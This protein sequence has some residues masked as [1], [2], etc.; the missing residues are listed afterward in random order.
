MDEEYRKSDVAHATIMRYQ[1]LGVYAINGPNWER[2][3]QTLCD[4]FTE[5]ICDYY[6][7]ISGKQG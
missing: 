4:N 5:D 2:D 3:L 1:D 7:K 6:T